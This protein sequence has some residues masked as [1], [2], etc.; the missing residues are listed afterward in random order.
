MDKFY[1]EQDR[2]L[3]RDLRTSE[4]VIGNTILFKQIAAGTT[5]LEFEILDDMKDPGQHLHIIP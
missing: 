3:V 5:R 4:W 2:L 1:A